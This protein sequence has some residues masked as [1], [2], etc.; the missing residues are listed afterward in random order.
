MV[1]AKIWVRNRG[2]AFDSLQTG[3][4]SLRKGRD[5]K[6]EASPKWTSQVE[7]RTP[8]KE[9]DERGRSE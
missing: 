7:E 4:S 1:R 5:G 6:E 9:K 2:M 3:V 8:A